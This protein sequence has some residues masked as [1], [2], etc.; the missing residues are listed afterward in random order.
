MAI[1]T[2][3]DSIAQRRFLLMTDLAECGSSHHD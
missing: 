1:A 2:R 3:L